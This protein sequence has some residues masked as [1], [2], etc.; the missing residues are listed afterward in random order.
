MDYHKIGESTILSLPSTA[1]EIPSYDYGTRSTGSTNAT[2]T[3]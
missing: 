2:N 3:T 1:A